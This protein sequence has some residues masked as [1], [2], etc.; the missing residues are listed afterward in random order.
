MVPGK[1][2]RVPSAS[3]VSWRICEKKKV[4]GVGNDS[5]SM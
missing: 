1:Q 5:K 4:G 2:E 3:Q